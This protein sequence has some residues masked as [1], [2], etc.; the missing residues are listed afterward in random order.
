MGIMTEDTKAGLQLIGIFL[1]VWILACIII[2]TLESLGLGDAI[3][4]D[5]KRDDVWPYILFMG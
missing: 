5:L 2:I 4:E 1:L 3:R